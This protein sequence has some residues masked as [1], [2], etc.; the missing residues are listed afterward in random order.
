MI[1]VRTNGDGTV[2]EL[3]AENASVHLEDLGDGLWY[4]RVESVDDVVRF[5]TLNIAR[6]AFVYESENAKIRLTD[7]APQTTKPTEVGPE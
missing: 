2:D 5:V 6:T 4:L 3:V 1:E 7:P